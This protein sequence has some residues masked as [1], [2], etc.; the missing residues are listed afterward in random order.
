[1]KNNRV[2]IISIAISLLL[3]II[4][5]L[6]FF[7]PFLS[8]I[9]FL[10]KLIPALAENIPVEQEKYNRI[11]YDLIETPD[12][13]ES[14]VNDPNRELA[15][16][17]NLNAA[18]EN[19]ETTPNSN[20]PYQEGISDIKDFTFLPPIN[21]QEQEQKKSSEQE[22][23]QA[24]NSG[25]QP[26]NPD[27]AKPEDPVL[28]QLNTVRD[29]KANY[30]NIKSSVANLGGMSFNTYEWNYAPYMLM[31]Q[32]KIQQNISPPPAFYAMGMIGG[33]N[34]IHFVVESDGKLSKVILIGSDTHISLDQTS[35]AAINVSAP[36]LPLPKDFPEEALE[37]NATFSYTISGRK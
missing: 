20:N 27:P 6:I 15:S 2:M 8:N 1:M 28:K 34:L 9:T 16:D 25:Y 13:P 31:M 5:L 10:T 4:L 30:E 37:I 32:R 22:A 21:A 29:L 33:E 3:H 36:F 14:E 17:K 24:S 18:D 19:P 35:L 26:G 7:S 23:E 11:T 12:A